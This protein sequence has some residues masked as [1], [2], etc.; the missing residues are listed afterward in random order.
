MSARAAYRV[1]VAG[2]GIAGAEALLAVRELAGDL[3]ALTLV[4]PRGELRL[5]VLEPGAAF[6]IGD[7]GRLRV[8]DIASAARAEVVRSALEHVDVE[9]RSIRTREGERIHCDALLVAVGSSAVPSVRGAVSWLPGA[10]HRDFLSCSPTRRRGASAG[11][12]PWSR[13]AAPGRFPPTSS[14]S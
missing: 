1:V 6:A 5:H 10:G 14:R 7:A 11:S 4:E 3:I 8:A 9:G 12:A 2:G 13:P